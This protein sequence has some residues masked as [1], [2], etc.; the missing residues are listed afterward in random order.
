MALGREKASRRVAIPA[1]IRL[2]PR[3][4]RH[5]PDR[6]LTADRG[7]RYREHAGADADDAVPRAEPAPRLAGAAAAGSV[8]GG[9]AGVPVSGGRG[10]GAVPACAR[11]SRGSGGHAAKD[12]RCP[13]SRRTFRRQG[14]QLSSGVR[15]RSRPGRRDLV[16]G[17]VERTVEQS[18]GSG[19]DRRRREYSFRV[20]T[21]RPPSFCKRP[22]SGIRADCARNR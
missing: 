8:A 21:A 22:Q 13:P 11:A 16:Y 9:G 6:T 7:A 15:L 17:C 12:R 10:P 2:S 14:L 3:D 4:A 20:G 1:D 5:A 19:S 18:H